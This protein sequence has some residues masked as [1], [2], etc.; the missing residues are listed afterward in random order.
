MHPSLIS[1][2]WLVPLKVVG[3]FWNWDEY[4]YEEYT[5][6]SFFETNASPEYLVPS[7]FL[8]VKDRVLF[9]FLPDQA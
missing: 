8:W 2:S 1:R 5:Q 3:Y 7:G 6:P 4:E 9:H